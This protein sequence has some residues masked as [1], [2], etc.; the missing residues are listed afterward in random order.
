ML[1]MRLFVIIKSLS[2]SLNFTLKIRCENTKFAFVNVW[3]N[4][5]SFH[6]YLRL[7]VINFSTE[8]LTEVNKKVLILYGRFLHLSVCGYIILRLM[9]INLKKKN[10]LGFFISFYKNYFCTISAKNVSILVL[11][12]KMI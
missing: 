7:L 4:R 12:F 10:R 9:C 5:I 2:S 1:H 3:T 8:Y 11:V 6:H